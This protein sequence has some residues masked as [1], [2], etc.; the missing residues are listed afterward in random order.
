MVGRARSRRTRAARTAKEELTTFA[1]PS[2][3]DVEF[4]FAAVI[5]AEL[6]GEELVHIHEEGPYHDHILQNLHDEGLSTVEDL[7]AD[8]F[9]PS[10]LVAVYSE[11]AYSDVPKTT[12]LE[13]QPFFQNPAARSLQGLVDGLKKA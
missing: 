4:H 7:E 6:D 3:I 11:E 8:E 9:D 12:R 5:L 1:E 10:T 2:E 13:W